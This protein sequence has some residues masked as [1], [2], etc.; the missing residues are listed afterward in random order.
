M[1]HSQTIWKK[2]VNTARMETFG[3][4]VSPTDPSLYAI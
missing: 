1:S 2:F 3:F 4:Q